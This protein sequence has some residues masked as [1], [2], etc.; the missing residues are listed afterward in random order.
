M[1]SRRTRTEAGGV[2]RRNPSAPAVTYVE[3]TA[4]AVTEPTT[5]GRIRP[6]HDMSVG[7]D[8]A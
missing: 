2:V 4:M 1:A 8:A 7:R 5:A 6:G 3:L